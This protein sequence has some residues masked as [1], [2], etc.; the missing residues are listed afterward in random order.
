MGTQVQTSIIIIN[1]KTPDLTVDCIRSVYAHE[2]NMSYEII[3]V[4]NDSN[5]GSIETIKQSCPNITCLEAPLNLGFAK[6]NNYAAT[7]ATGE[8]LLFLNSDAYLTKPFLE[9]L[10]QIYTENKSIGIIAPRLRN[11]DNTIQKSV[12]K[13]PTLWRALCESFF[14]ST[15]LPNSK[16]FGDY[17]KF[18]YQTSKQVDFVS[19]A[20]F[21]MNKSL[22]NKL[23][24]F[25]ESFFMYAEETDLAYRAIKTPSYFIPIGDVVHLGGGSQENVVNFNKYFFQSKLHY[26]QKHYGKSGLRKF[27]IIKIIGFGLRN[28]LLLLV[29]NFKKIK[30]NTQ[31]ILY[32]AKSFI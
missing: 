7:K 2:K 21:L 14:L 18:N 31:I 6:A 9:E 29:L 32:Y 15:L 10:I 24:G 13:F 30:F 12:F 25:D 28:I 26:H 19:G 16:I 5:D 20:C 3:V 17:R 27:I 1:Y 11:S 4:D 22:F 8:Y 23:K